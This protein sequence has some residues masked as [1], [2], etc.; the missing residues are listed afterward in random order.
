MEKF[1]DFE[2]KLKVYWLCEAR[3]QD[4]ANDLRKSLS[5]D[6]SGMS[7]DEF[8]QILDNVI[9]T[10]KFSVERYEALTGLD[11][12]SVDGVV[13]DLKILRGELFGGDPD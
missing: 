8:K 3:D 4:A 9:L 12:D 1:S 2:K 7:L 5:H 13:D 6:K 11:C 10:K